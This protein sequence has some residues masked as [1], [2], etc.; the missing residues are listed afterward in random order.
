MGGL[1][2]NNQLMLSTQERGFE[3]CGKFQIRVLFRGPHKK[4][5]RVLGSILGSRFWDTWAMNGST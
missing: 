5:Y 4:D 1:C 3:L 2:K